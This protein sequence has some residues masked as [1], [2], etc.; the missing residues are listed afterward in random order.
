MKLFVCNKFYILIY[1]D[2]LVNS[3]SS[4]SFTKKMHLQN[5]PSIGADRLIIEA[6]QSIYPM[7]SIIIIQKISF[8]F[9][10]LF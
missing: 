4:Q 3:F 10:A 2:P 5:G 9:G 6:D 8:V 1:R 7:M